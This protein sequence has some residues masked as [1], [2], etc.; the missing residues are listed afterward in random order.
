MLRALL[1]FALSFAHSFAQL[2]EL[3]AIGR[4][5]KAKGR[6]KLWA[7]W[8]GAWWQSKK[9]GTRRFELGVVPWTVFL[10]V[11]EL[12]VGIQVYHNDIRMAFP[13]SLGQILGC[14]TSLTW[15]ALRKGRKAATPSA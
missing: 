7:I 9:T 1:V 8:W 4:V 3:R 5:W 2:E 10:V 15:R 12:W 14:A 6:K 13:D 11:V